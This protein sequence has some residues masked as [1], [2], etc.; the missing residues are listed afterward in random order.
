MND[1]SQSGKRWASEM[2]TV[3]EPVEYRSRHNA[4]AGRCYVCTRDQNRQG[5]Y[6]SLYTDCISHL[7][8]PH[9]EAIV[10]VLIIVL[11]QS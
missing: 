11:Q 1:A 3:S 2:L 7:F 9:F 8:G 6:E 5:R 10:L 4:L